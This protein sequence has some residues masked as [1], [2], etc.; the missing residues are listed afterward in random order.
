MPYQVTF[1]PKS[2]RIRGRTT[3]AFRLKSRA[4]REA[5]KINKTSPDLT[6]ARTVIAKPGTYYQIV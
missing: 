5:D 4:N 3:I 6:D 2:G 1:R